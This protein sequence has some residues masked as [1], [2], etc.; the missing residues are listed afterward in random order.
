ME[1]TGSFSNRVTLEQRPE[2]CEGQRQANAW[3][4]CAQQMEQQAG[5]GACPGSRQITRRLW[6]W[7]LGA[8]EETECAHLWGR[9]ATCQ[10]QAQTHPIYHLIYASQ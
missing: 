4:K 10:T 1:G 7:E 6:G 9:R 5:S 8:G 2:G 3:G